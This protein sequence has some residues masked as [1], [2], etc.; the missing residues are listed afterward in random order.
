MELPIAS[1]RSLQLLKCPS[2]L[3]MRPPWKQP[4]HR[5]VTPILVLAI[6]NVQYITISL[7]APRRAVI[8]VQ[9]P[10]RL[11]P[12]LTSHPR[13]NLVKPYKTDLQS[14]AIDRQ[15]ENRHL[16]RRYRLNP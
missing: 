14:Q 11:L 5:L 2:S 9:R 1:H 6:E 7:P 10:L 13:C 8:L 16:R 4:C 12:V 15:R 3:Q